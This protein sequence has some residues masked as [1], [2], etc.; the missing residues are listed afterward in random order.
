MSIPIIG[1]C[2]DILIISPSDYQKNY[3]LEICDNY[4]KKWKMEFNP[5]KSNYTC[6]GDKIISDGIQMNGTNIPYNENF[7]YLGLAIGTNEYK[8][9]LFDDKFKKCE[10]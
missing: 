4:A 5:A 6:F 2:D 3:L 7:V 9:K 8:K 1:Y 10:R